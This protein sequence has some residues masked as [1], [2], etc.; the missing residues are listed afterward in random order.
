MRYHFHFTSHYQ[1]V[2][3]FTVYDRETHKEHRIRLDTA[4]GVASYV[5]EGIPPDVLDAFNVWREA[6]YISEVE[7][8]AERYGAAEAANVAPFRLAS[9]S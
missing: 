3:D 7:H 4:T 2:S 9:A 8:I 5:G 1:G 6:K